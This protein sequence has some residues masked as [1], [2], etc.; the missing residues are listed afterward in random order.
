MTD[1]TPTPTTPESPQQ[2]AYDL[3]KAVVAILALAGVAIP[4]A[5]T[6][7]SV[8][9]QLAAA[10]VTIVGGGATLLS[11]I[12]HRAKSQTIATQAAKLAVAEAKAKAPARSVPR[13]TS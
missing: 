3:I 12:S 10:A 8:E 9:M 13:M 4:A 5:L 11:Y 7:Q 1:Q 6:S 2:A